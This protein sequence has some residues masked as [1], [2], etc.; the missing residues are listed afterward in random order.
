MK[1]DII[2]ID[3]SISEG[4]SI[5]DEDLSIGKILIDKY[6]PFEIGRAHV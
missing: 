6:Y 4:D 2:N 3:G 1:L 5:L